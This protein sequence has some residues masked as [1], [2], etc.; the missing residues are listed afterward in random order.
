MRARTQDPEATAARLKALRVRSRSLNAGGTAALFLGAAFFLLGKPAPQGDTFT[1]Q[2]FV[3]TSKEGVPVADLGSEGDRPLLR[4]Y[5]PAGN[6]RIELS[7]DEDGARVRMFDRT[8]MRR[9][10]LAEEEGPRLWFYDEKGTS[11]AWVA[12]NDEGETTVQASDAGGQTRVRLG[13]SAN[14]DPSLQIF[15]AAGNAV[16]SKP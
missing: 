13:V 2:K 14:G 11:R 1:A 9:L 6:R 10:T 7:V 16:T 12:M 15:D 4:L 5:D 8:G 3:V